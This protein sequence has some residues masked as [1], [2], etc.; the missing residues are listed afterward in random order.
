MQKPKVLSEKSNNPNK[1]SGINHNNFFINITLLT[2]L[3]LIFL[4]GIF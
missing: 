3:M 4:R 2:T 1:Q